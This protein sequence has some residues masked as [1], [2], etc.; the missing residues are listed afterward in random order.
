MLIFTFRQIWSIFYFTDIS[1]LHIFSMGVYMGN[2]RDVENRPSCCNANMVSGRAYIQRAG[3][4][5]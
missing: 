2:C 1:L 3:G 5:C 4:L